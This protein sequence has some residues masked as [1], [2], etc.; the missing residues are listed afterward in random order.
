VTE[1]LRLLTINEVA[2]LLRVHRATV[3]RFVKDGKLPQPITLGTRRRFKAT[4][5]EAHLASLS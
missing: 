5:I 4:D 2:E 3:W 1:N